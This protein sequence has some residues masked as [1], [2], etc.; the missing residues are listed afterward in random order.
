MRSGVGCA[1]GYD[2]VTPN[3]GR[4]EYAVVGELMGAREWDESG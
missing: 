1:L 3:G 2:E 4:R